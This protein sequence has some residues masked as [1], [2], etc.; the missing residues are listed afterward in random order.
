MYFYRSIMLALVRFRVWQLMAGVGVVALLSWIAIR[1]NMDTGMSQAVGHVNVRLQFR[2]RDSE[3]AMPIDGATIR[4]ADPDSASDPEE[5][6]VLE[7][8]NGRDG[9]VSKALDSQFG[10]SRGSHLDDSAPSESPTLFG[11]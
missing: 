6:Y 9:N 4:L 7:L 5:P 3:S 10:E 8:K 1:W 11:K 2:V